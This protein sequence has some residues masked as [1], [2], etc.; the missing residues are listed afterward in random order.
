MC[1]WELGTAPPRLFVCLFI[2]LLI[3]LLF[4]YAPMGSLAAGAGAAP[5]QEVAGDK[6]AV[7]VAPGGFAVRFLCI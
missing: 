2:Y 7:A 6:A 5:P 4:I 3:S 1:V